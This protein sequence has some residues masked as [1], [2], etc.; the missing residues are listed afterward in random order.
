MIDTLILTTLGIDTP[1]SEVGLMRAKEIPKI[2]ERII[3]PKFT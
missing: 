3:L 1:E 2:R